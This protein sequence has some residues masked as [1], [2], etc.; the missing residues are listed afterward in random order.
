MSDGVVQLPIVKNHVQ[1]VLFVSCLTYLSFSCILHTCT[2]NFS[3]TSAAKPGITTSPCSSAEVLVTHKLLWN[4][5]QCWK[6]C[7]WRLPYLLD[8][9][10]LHA[11]KP[12]METRSPLWPSLDTMVVIRQSCKAWCFLPCG[13]CSFWS[14]RY[15]AHR[16]KENVGLP[17]LSPCQI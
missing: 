12:S 11:P 5:L 7:G 8:H 1:K 9:Q 4:G 3:R 13:V 14:V 2:V 6:T 10:D 16:E 17:P 15:A